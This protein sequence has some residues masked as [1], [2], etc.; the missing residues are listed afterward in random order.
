MKSFFRIVALC[1][2][3]SAFSGIKAGAQ[4]NPNAQKEEKEFFEGIDREVERLTD[5]LDLEYWQVFYVDSILTHDYQ[6]MQEELKELSDKKVSNTDLYYDV[7]Y[8]WLDSI[9][10]AY[11]K[12]FDERQWAKYLKSGAEREK[13]ARDKKRNK[14]K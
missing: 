7:Q 1:L 6:A 14:T 2:A 9:Y 11:Q 10:E 5:L 8:K 3:I 13:K 4:E 12:V